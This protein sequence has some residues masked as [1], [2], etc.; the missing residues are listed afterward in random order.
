VRA[1]AIN[2]QFLPKKDLKWMRTSRECQLYTHK[3]TV[4][5]GAL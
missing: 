4:N 5:R 3:K 1:F 2:R